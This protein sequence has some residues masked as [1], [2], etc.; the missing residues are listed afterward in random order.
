[1]A[2]IQPRPILITGGGRRIGLALARHFLARQQPVMISYR[3]WYPAIDELRNAGAV[4]LHADF[5]TDDSILAFAE[6]V[7]AQ[8]AAGLRAVIHNASGWMAEK[9]GIPLTTVL[10]SMMQIHVNA[11]YCSTMRWRACYAVT[12]R[13]PA[14]LFTLPT[15]SWSAAATSILPM[16]PARRQWII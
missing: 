4:C 7:K 12:D 16:R 5:S 14:I 10:A 13:P 9:P 1:M 8:A 15:T 3:T 11:P 2:D 6:E